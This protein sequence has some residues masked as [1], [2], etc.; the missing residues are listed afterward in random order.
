VGNVGDVV[1]SDADDGDGERETDRDEETYFYKCGE[2][3]E[4][5]MEEGGGIGDGT[6][7]GPLACRGA[8]TRTARRRQRADTLTL[9]LDPSAKIAYGNSLSRHSHP[10]HSTPVTPSAYRKKNHFLPILSS[11]CTP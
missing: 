11:H 8:D 6:L 1:L 9:P 4:V 5:W 3:E 7:Y 2:R 10:H